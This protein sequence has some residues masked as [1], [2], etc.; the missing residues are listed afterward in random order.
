M[1]T[2]GFVMIGFFT[3]LSAYAVNAIFQNTSSTSGQFTVMDMLA[4]PSQMIVYSGTLPPN[5]SITV[6]LQSSPD[7]GAEAQW[8]RFATPGKFVYE[9]GE[10]QVIQ[11]Q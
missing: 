5:A 3:S 2:L 11:M 8:F 10:G 1:R 9:I 6:S 4:N 7:D